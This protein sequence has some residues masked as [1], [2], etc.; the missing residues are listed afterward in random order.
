MR[1]A[2]AWVGVLAVA[3]MLGACS[4]APAPVE[5]EPAA[6]SSAITAP[7]P[8]QTSSTLARVAASHMQLTVYASQPEVVPGERLSLVIDSVPDPGIHVYAPSVVGYLPINLRVEPQPGVT[9]GEAIYPEPGTYYFEPLD[10]TVPVYSL[11]FQLRQELVIDASAFDGLPAGEPLRLTG[12]LF[13]Q[14]CDDRL[15]FSPREVPLE[16]TLALAPAAP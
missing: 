15:C 6:G 2:M 16:W 3:V 9:L 5:T 4:D 12:T 11:P 14:A 1:R 7:V 13:Y 8:A 10:E